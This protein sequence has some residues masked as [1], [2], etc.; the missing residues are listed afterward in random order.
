MMMRWRG[1]LH[2]YGRTGLA[3]T[4]DAGD[5]P[6]IDARLALLKLALTLPREVRGALEAADRFELAVERLEADHA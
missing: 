3:A 6:A 4:I 5:V 1:T 2:L